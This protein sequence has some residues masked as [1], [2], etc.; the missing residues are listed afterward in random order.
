ML[1]LISISIHSLMLTGRR[2]A[3]PPV[4]RFLSVVNRRYISLLGQGFWP[5]ATD[6]CLYATA[7]TAN[8]HTYIHS[9]SGDRTHYPRVQT[10]E[11]SKYIL[12]TA[13]RY[14]LAVGTASSDRG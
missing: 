12:W 5:I 8:T 6:L 14:I 13:E 3:W 9:V 7:Q 2:A 10:V 4:F 11:D 1:V